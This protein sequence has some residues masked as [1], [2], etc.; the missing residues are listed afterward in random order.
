MENAKVPKTKTLYRLDFPK[1]L[2]LLVTA[3]EDGEIDAGYLYPLN[4]VFADK[5]MNLVAFLEGWKR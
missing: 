4:F 5:G 2:S 3:K 1:R